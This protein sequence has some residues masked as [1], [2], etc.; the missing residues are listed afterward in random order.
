MQE[1]E[2]RVLPLDDLSDRHPGLT[3]ALADAYHEAAR[4]CLDRHHNPPTEFHLTDNDVSLHARVG[5][6]ATN[7]QTRRAWANAAEATRDGAY[8]M[9]IASTELS[10]NLVA[11]SRAETKTG[12]DYYVAPAGTNDD[13]ME[14][15]LR[16]EVSGTDLDEKQV[17]YRLNQKVNQAEKGSSNLPALAAVVGFRASV[18]SIKS[19]EIG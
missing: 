15:W 7:D 12:A 2:Q 6:T 17:S 19:V 3:K 11:V 18:I 16:L 5:W 9:A 13:D 14:S 10:R 4:V 1:I 8:A